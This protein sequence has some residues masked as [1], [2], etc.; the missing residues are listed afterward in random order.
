MGSGLARQRGAR[1][2]PSDLTAS[3]GQQGDHAGFLCGKQR[4]ASFTLI[5][6]CLV[7][8]VTSVA[9]PVHQG[10][11]WTRR[12]TSAR[13]SYSATQ[14]V[15][16]PSQVAS[17]PR[18]NA[19]KRLCIIGRSVVT[20]KW[21]ANDSLRSRPLHGGES[22]GRVRCEMPAHFAALEDPRI[23]RTRRHHCW[24]SSSSPSVPWSAAPTTSSPW[25]SSA[26]ASRAWLEKFL[27]LPNGIPSHDT[28]GRV[29]AAL[30][31]EHFIR[32]FLSWVEAFAK[33]RPGRSSASTARPRGPA[34]T[35]PRA[36]TRCTWSAPG[37]RPTGW[38]SAR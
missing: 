5:G 27:E 33:S 3:S 26:R 4:V 35:G 28:F 13:R 7:L 32:C 30:D 18:V 8:A 22:H 21:A 36:S 38:S 9:S 6:L 11:W 2:S 31:A 19:S 34:W 24:T 12:S 10:V 20:D 14:S 25:R 15:P 17:L 1:T 16:S 23:E 29:F 37:P